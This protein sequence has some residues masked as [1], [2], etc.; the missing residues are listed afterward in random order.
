M[1]GGLVGWSGSGGASTRA[2]STEY[3]VL[4]EFVEGKM[5]LHFEQEGPEPRC[6]VICSSSVPSTGGPIRVEFRIPTPAKQNRRGSILGSV[7]VLLGSFGVG[8]MWSRY[9]CLLLLGL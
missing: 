3:Y 2:G 9:M 8:Y 7:G 6:I 5:N 4:H 1:V